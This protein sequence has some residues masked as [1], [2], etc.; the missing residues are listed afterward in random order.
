MVKPDAAT[1]F[2]CC[3]CANDYRWKQNPQRKIARHDH[4]FRQ[5]SQTDGIFDVHEFENWIN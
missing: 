1:Q 5:S 3:K 2:C 4:S